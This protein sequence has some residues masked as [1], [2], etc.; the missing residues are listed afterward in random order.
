MILNAAAENVRGIFIPM[1]KSDFSV[2]DTEIGLM[3]TVSSMGYLIFTYIGG[4]LCEKIGQKK[5]F[6]SGF[7]AIIISLSGLWA[8]KSYIILLSCMFIMNIGL[9]LISIAINTIIPVL[10]ISFQAV[11]M[12]LTHF[13][14]GL[15]STVVQRLSGVLL[16]NGVAWRTIYLGEAILFLLVLLFF[17][18]IKIPNTHKSKANNGEQ[19]KNSHLLKNKLV[20]FYMLGLGFYVFAEMGTASWFVNFIEKTYA[21]DKSRS[22]FYLAL[23][24]GLLTVG[25]LIGGFI[26]EKV[27]YLKL[28]LIS[29]SAAALLFAIGISIGESGLVIISISGLFFAVTFPTVVV[30]ISK[31]FKD[32]GAYATGIIVTASSTFN[33]V[34]NMVMGYLNDTIGVYNS[35]YLIPL[36]LAV[37]FFFIFAIYKNVSSTTR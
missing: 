30:T 26:A 25:R 8:T 36:G 29:L 5:V 13:C 20:Y 2:N 7:I 35:F 10:F 34:L 19:T 3:L 22:S 31:V 15:G 16:F 18:P 32:H 4:I 37:S 1:F 27:G 28:V 23:F 14:Y 33:M 12:N 21:Y 9:A 17:L 11:L 24:F 6:I